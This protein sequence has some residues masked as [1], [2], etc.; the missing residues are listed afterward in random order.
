MEHILSWN[1]QHLANPNKLRHLGVICDRME[2][3]A[4]TIVTPP[5]LWENRD[6]EEN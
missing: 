2:M 6:E 1:V 4:P 5:A 3:K